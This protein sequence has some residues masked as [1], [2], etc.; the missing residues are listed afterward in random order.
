M[1]NLLDLQASGLAAIQ[2]QGDQDAVV[3]GRTRPASWTQVLEVLESRQKGSRGGVGGLDEGGG[4]SLTF[5]AAVLALRR[6]RPGGQV[7]LTASTAERRSVSDASETSLF[8]T[9]PPALNVF[10]V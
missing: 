5:T 4:S 8:V 10:T 9:F 1:I 7:L 3:D 6:L 2:G